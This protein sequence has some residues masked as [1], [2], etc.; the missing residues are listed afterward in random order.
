M[1]RRLPALGALVA[2]ASLSAMSLSSCSSTAANTEVAS[3]AGQKLTADELEQI[4]DGNTTGEDVRAVI[5]NWLQ[6]AILGGDTSVIGSVEDLQNAVDQTNAALISQNLTVAQEE[7][8]ANGLDAS[9]LCLAAIPLDAAVDPADVVAEIVAGTTFADAAAQYSIDDTLKANGGLLVDGNGNECLQTSSF[10][11]EL[12]GAMA[13][14]GAEIGTPVGIT[15][16]QQGAVVMLRPWTELSDASKQTAASGLAQTIG[17]QKLTQ[18][19]DVI[20]N[21]RYG[22]WE[23]STARVVP[24]SAPETTSPPAS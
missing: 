17:L 10:T 23:S 5:S 4:M 15:V 18:A 11:P 9:F 16:G 19:D 1:I 2:V 24:F 7:Y 8:E 22:K 6:V 12:L 14:S 3:A 21:P 13:D 20:V